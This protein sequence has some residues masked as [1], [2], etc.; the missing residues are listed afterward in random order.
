[1]SRSAF[2]LRFKTLL[3]ESPL[4]YLARWRMLSA[5]RL[6]QGRDATVAE[7][8]TRVGY[9]TLA[10]FSVSTRLAVAGGGVSAGAAVGAA[11][12]D[13]GLAGAAGATVGA[14]GATVGAAGAGGTGSPGLRFGP[15][16][17]SSTASRSSLGLRAGGG[18]VGRFLRRLAITD[19]LDLVT[20]ER[21]AAVL[22]QL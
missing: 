3:H 7:I 6:L 8:A 5:K 10:A 9:A 14:A 4:A 11:G 16:F 1:M 15:C 12:A 13:V 19:S 22:E 21:R 2:A 20:S 17:V 18:P